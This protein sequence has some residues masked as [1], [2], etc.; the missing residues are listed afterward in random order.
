MA[1]KRIAA[2]WKSCTATSLPPSL[3]SCFLSLCILALT[4]IQ[5][6][7]MQV[8]KVKSG[9]FPIIKPSFLSPER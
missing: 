4:Q 5:T 8:V 6:L 3:I 1:V 9:M 2:T 7:T